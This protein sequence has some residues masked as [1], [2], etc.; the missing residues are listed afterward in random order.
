MTAKDLKISAAS[1]MVL[2]VIQHDLDR[3]AVHAHFDRRIRL[4][5]KMEAVMYEHGGLVTG[6]TAATRVEVG[7]AQQPLVATAVPRPGA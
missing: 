1:V 5:G 3:Q 7:V 6:W 2:A 4:N